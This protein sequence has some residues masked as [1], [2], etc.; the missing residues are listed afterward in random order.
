MMDAVHLW[1]EENPVQRPEADPRVQVSKARQ[2][3]S[4]KEDSCRN[5]RDRD[6]E[7][8]DRRDH[9]YRLAGRLEPMVS[10]GGGDVEVLFAVMDLVQRPEPRRR[11]LQAMPPVTEEVGDGNP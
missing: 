11:V 9:Y 1:R 2:P 5:R 6:E 7:I 3:E 10:V 8:R 4:G